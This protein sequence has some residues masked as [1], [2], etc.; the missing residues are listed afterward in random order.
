MTVP[1]FPGLDGGELVLETE[2]GASF[3]LGFED[4]VTIDDGLDGATTG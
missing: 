3:S 1:E 4:V 2:E